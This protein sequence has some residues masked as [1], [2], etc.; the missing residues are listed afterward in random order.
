MMNVNN[1]LANNSQT[2]VN[3]FNE[4]VLT[5]SETVITDSLINKGN[6]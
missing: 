5:T 2:I 6:Y 1:N 3:A 4:Y